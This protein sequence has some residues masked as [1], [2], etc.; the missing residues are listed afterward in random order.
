MFPKLSLSF[1]LMNESIQEVNVFSFKILSHSM[2]EMLSHSRNEML[3]H[4]RNEILSHSSLNDE[5]GVVCQEL[6]YSLI[7]VCEL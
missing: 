4:S 3:S 6:D 2:N 1:L 5:S 7:H